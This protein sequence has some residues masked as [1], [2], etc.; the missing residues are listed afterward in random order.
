MQNEKIN[1]NI[2]KLKVTG[3]STICTGGSCIGVKAKDCLMRKMLTI[4]FQ[5]PTLVVQHNHN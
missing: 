2:Q 3:V 4:N 5:N 1:T